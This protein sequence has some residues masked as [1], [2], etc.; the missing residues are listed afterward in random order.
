MPAAE[1]PKRRVIPP[2]TGFDRVQTGLAE[3]GRVGEEGVGLAVEL[4][5]SDV[6]VLAEEV[7]VVGVAVLPVI[8][9]VGVDHVLG[10][11][12]PPRLSSITGFG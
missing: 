10:P 4:L 8:E 11:G 2:Q 6:L 1:N 5:V 12:E 9:V 3:P 7:A